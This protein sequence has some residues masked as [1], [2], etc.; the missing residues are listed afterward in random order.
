MQQIVVITP[1]GGKNWRQRAV[2]CFNNGNDY[3]YS[4]SMRPRHILDGSWNI[5]DDVW[6]QQNLGHESGGK[7]QPFRN[8]SAVILTSP[9]ILCR[10]CTKRKTQFTWSSLSITWNKLQRN[11]CTLDSLGTTRG[12]ATCN[13][14]FFSLLSKRRFGHVVRRF[15]PM[16]KSKLTIIYIYYSYTQVA[17]LWNSSQEVLIQITSVIF[18]G[19]FDIICCKY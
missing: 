14:H 7:M 6:F 19:N 18:L 13:W 4:L 12:W 15:Y 2:E 16:W 10:S 1:P 8:M 9:T 3:E 11:F 17:D 5:F